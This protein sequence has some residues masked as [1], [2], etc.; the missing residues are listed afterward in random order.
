MSVSLFL[1]RLIFCKDTG[2][3]SDGVQTGSVSILGSDPPPG[4]GGHPPDGEPGAVC[5]SSLSLSDALNE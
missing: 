1:D 5:G 2:K 3:R 4:G